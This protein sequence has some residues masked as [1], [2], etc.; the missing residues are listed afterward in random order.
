MPS[1]SYQSSTSSSKSQTYAVLHINSLCIPLTSVWSTFLACLHVTCTVK[2]THVASWFIPAEVGLLTHV[3]SAEA[4][5]PHRAKTC[6]L[7][8][9]RTLS[10]S[11]E[12]EHQ[13]SLY[14]S[15]KTKA[16]LS[17][18]NWFTKCQSWGGKLEP[19]TCTNAH[20]SRSTC[21]SRAE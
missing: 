5:S 7:W 16:S 8:R 4:K 9:H 1:F 20:T 19:R 3:F 15:P 6:L 11:F 14:K 13:I 21:G 17:D 12:P 18:G 2:H 10:E